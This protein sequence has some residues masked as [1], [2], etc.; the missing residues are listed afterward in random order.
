[1]AVASRPAPLM[2]KEAVDIPENGAE[3]GTHSV[4]DHPSW[5]M[6][7]VGPILAGH[8]SPIWM[9]EDC[10]RGIPLQ[11]QTIVIMI[12]MCVEPIAKFPSCQ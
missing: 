1:M 7:P 11:A 3:E 10:S 4:R 2:H 12:C 6:L 8:M 5:Q 9:A